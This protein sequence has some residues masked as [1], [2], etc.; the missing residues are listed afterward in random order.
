MM[1]GGRQRCGVLAAVVATAVDFAAV[2]A[3]FA[4]AA[5]VDFAAAAAVDFAAAAAV[6]FAAA[7]DQGFAFAAV[8]VKYHFF[9]KATG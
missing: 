2:A 6:D 3:D 5:A 7:V 9:A 1:V 8:K 4:A